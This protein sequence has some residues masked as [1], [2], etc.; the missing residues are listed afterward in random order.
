MFNILSHQRNANQ[1]NSEISSDTCKNGQDQK[2]WWQLILERLWGKRNTP[3]LLVG[4]QA[5]TTF[6]DVS[7]A[8]SRKLE[9]NF[10]QDPGIPLLGIYPKDAQSCHKD[11]YSTM[12]I[13]ALFVIARTWKQPKCP[14]TEGQIRKCTFIQ[15]RTHCRK[16]NDILRFVGKWMELENIILS[17]ITQT[18]KDNYHMYSLISDF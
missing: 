18:Q 14:L 3:A 13:A 12:F 8:I 16:N 15:W 1:K 7:M 4:M 2:H 17:E 9:N 10:P 11:M 5:G 6:L